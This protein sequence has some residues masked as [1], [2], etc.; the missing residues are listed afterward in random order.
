LIF[1]L[2]LLL[3]FL[4]YQSLHSLLLK[5]VLLLPSLL[6]LLLLKCSRIILHTFLVGSLILKVLFGIWINQFIK[7]SLLFCT[8]H[9][10]L[11]D[12]LLFSE[13]ILIDLILQLFT[14][15]LSLFFSWFSPVFILRK[16]FRIALF[17]F[18]S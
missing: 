12:F 9:K 2:L 18:F 16:W 7:I 15:L 4:I 17:H 6:L 10:L 1:K 5:F 14:I 3:E 13:F 11:L 8:I